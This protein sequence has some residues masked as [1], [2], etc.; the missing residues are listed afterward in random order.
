MHLTTMFPALAS[1]RRTH[2]A[3]VVMEPPRPLRGLDQTARQLP[4]FVQTCPVTLKYREL[5][6]PIRWSCFPERNPNHPWPGVRPDPRAP[7]AAAFLIKLDQGHNSMGQLRTFLCEHPALVWFLGFPLVESPHFP[8]GFDAARCLPSQ[9]HFCNVLRTMPNRMLQFLLDETV[10]LFEQLVA[11]SDRLFGD[12]ISLDTKHIIA[13]CR[14]N[15]PKER[16]VDRFDK[17]KQPKGDPDCRLGCK[18]RTNQRPRTPTT[19]GVPADSV[20]VGTFYWGYGSGIVV[21]KVPDS[22]EIVLAEFTQPFNA[23]ETSYFIPLMEQTERRLARRPRFGA[24]DAAFDAHYIYDYFHEA[25]G[26]AA[27]P[28]SN[29]GAT[30]FSFD[31]DGLPLCRA[32]LSMPPKRFFWNR[33]GLVEQRQATYACPLLFPEVTGSP[34]PVDHAK[35]HKGGCSH[36]LGISPG[37]RIRYQLD[38]NSD[39]YKRLYNQR[40]AAERVFSL[41]KALGIERPKLRNQCSIANLNT[42]I[43]VL[44]NLRTFHRTRAAEQTLTVR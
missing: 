10:L 6:G 11:G 30:S 38:R 5:L 31:D 14:E 15:N 44:L 9:R 27:I 36:T 42:L 16:M 26:F 2:Q 33:R 4:A 1:W 32:G 39:E 23:G 13:W 18:E 24:L 12:E 35:W 3:S 20:A 34:C 21:S 19:D 25:G 43:Y 22:G 17:S 37:V 41:A 7:F 8:W 28:R 40:T 29:R